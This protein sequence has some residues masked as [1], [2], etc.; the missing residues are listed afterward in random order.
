MKFFKRYM[1][2]FLILTV[3]SLVAIIINLTLNYLASNY[4]VD[5]IGGFLI[6]TALITVPYMLGEILE[7]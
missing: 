1:V 4:E 3:L 5:G 2:G 6:V 7:R